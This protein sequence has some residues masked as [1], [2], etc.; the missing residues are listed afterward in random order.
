MVS[1]EEGIKEIEVFKEDMIT[2][3]LMKLGRPETGLSKSRRTLFGSG[4]CSLELLNSLKEGS[5]GSF[6]R[7]IYYIDDFVISG[8]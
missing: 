6:C 2:T 3:R 5:R 7:K 8:V 4:C 1:D